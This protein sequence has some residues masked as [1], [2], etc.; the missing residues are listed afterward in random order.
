MP[1]L[2][3]SINFNGFGTGI[4]EI[5]H[6][7]ATARTSSGSTCRYPVALLEEAEQKRE[8]APHWRRQWVQDLI[9]RRYT[10]RFTIL[11]WERLRW[12]ILK[13]LSLS[14]AL[15]WRRTMSFRAVVI[16]FIFMFECV[17]CVSR[18]VLSG[19]CVGLLRDKVQVAL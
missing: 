13:I 2:A 16:K 15:S 5:S 3:W 11:L 4:S 10:F 8:R 14:F 18:S 7:A 9:L 6:V 17:A 12:I 1:Y 19:S